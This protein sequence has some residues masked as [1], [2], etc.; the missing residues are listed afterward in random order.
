MLTFTVRGRLGVGVV[1]VAAVMSLLRSA[2]IS[3][4]VFLRQSIE[5]YLTTGLVVGNE[6]I[7]GTGG[8]GGVV[9][10]R[11]GRGSG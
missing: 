8:G 3:P 6:D 1:V 5:I 9:C 4:G 11:F 2:R 7:C 10:R